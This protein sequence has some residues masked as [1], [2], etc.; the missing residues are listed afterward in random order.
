MGKSRQTQ[1][2]LT[3][4][5]KDAI[6]E[7][8]STPLP[9]GVDYKKIIDDLKPGDRIGPGGEIIP[10]R[11]PMELAREVD[12]L[13]RR[14]RA[15]RYVESVGFN[16]DESTCIV[17]LDCGHAGTVDDWST[18]SNGP[19]FRAVVWCLSCAAGA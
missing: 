13:L 17:T 12:D 5:M 10:W 2:A 1:D 18:A 11:S 19:F 4:E 6:E 7:V 14:M 16:V 9:Y 15:V 3:D 8:M